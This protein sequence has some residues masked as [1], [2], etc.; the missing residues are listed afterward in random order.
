[1]RNLSKIIKFKYIFTIKKSKE[2]KINENSNWYI[3]IQGQLHVTQRQKCLFAIWSGENRPLKTEIIERDDV[4][5]KTK[6]EPKVVGFYTDWILPEIVD[7]R[8]ARGMPLRE[9]ETVVSTPS[10]VSVLQ[11]LQVVSPND[12]NKEN[13]PM[14][15][16]NAVFEHILPSSPCDSDTDYEPLRKKIYTF[17][18][19]PTSVVS[20]F[21]GNRKNKPCCSK[22]LTFDEM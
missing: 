4:F 18:E 17:D 1:M 2:T 20:E 13:K 7:S 8:R 5:W 19:S 6:I 14:C 21:I 11:P 16:K 22:Q 15:K 3:Q 9:K 12:A 10:V